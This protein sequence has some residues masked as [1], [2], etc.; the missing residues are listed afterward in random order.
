MEIYKETYWLGHKKR[1][2][3][4]TKK[5][6]LKLDDG[7]FRKVHKNKKEKRVDLFEYRRKTEMTE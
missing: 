5:F 6:L 4:A 7:I 3:K 2:I 1:N